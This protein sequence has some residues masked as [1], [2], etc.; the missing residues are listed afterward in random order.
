MTVYQQQTPVKS[1]AATLA[2][3]TGFGPVR[4]IRLSFAGRTEVES[5]EFSDSGL[6]AVQ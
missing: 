3:R 6:T 4:E 2:V 1:G 5:T